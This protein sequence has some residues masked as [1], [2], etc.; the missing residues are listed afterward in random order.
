MDQCLIMQGE[1]RG[2]AWRIA[3]SCEDSR[4]GMPRVACSAKTQGL[5]G[6]SSAY[7]K[8]GRVKI[9]G[10]SSRECSRQA[11]RSTGRKGGSPSCLPVLRNYLEVPGQARCAVFAAGAMD[12]RGE[13]MVWGA[14]VGK[15]AQTGCRRDG[16]PEIIGL[17]RA[18]YMGGRADALRGCTQ[19][20]C[21]KRRLWQAFAA[22]A[23][24]GPSQFRIQ[25]K[26]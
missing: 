14:R 20:P 16:A 17:V 8:H 6:H 19:V 7:Q 26:Y 2:R 4:H 15:G 9:R 13:D 3:Y 25:S 23:R 12:V 21:R 24:G 11:N 1:I 22:A 5:P 10:I 18:C